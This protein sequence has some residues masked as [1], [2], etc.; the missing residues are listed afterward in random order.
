M[1]A[2]I[3]SEKNTLVTQYHDVFKENGYEIITYNWVLK[4][5]DNLEEIDPDI[6][7]INIS[8]YPRQW[9]VLVQYI[10]TVFGDKSPTVFIASD[11]TI[12]EKIK[13]EADVLGCKEFSKKEINVQST[14]QDDNNVETSKLILNTDI[15]EQKETNITE[16]KIEQNDIK[17]EKSSILQEPLNEIKFQHPKTK[18]LISGKI[19]NYND[20]MFLFIPDFKSTLKLLRFG[21]RINNAHFCFDEKTLDINIQV[22]GINEDSIEM[23]I[24]SENK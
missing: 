21:M 18:E 11:Q 2:L 7:L 3:V 4:A 10:H 6:I 5:L 14:I 1:K 19:K 9:K 13:K 24:L 22:Q 15:I 16:A 17:Q 8:D 20:P 23:C 12:S